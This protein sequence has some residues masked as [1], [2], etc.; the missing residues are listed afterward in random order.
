MAE[1]RK[2]R[3]FIFVLSVWLIDLLIYTVC[4]RI[5]NL[6]VSA[7]F[8]ISENESFTYLQGHFSPSGKPK[9][10]ERIAMNQQTVTTLKTVHI[11]AIDFFRADIGWLSMRFR[12][13]LGNRQA[14]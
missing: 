14:V 4:T 7:A 13:A 10:D 8:P 1:R 9:T 2:L 5:A 12:M 3:R 6:P 11:F